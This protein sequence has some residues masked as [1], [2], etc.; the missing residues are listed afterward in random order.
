MQRTVVG[1]LIGARWRGYL[2]QLLH[3][4]LSLRPSLHLQLGGVRLL[5]LNEGVVS[6]DERAIRADYSIRR[7]PEMGIR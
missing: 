4:G 6:S 1:G 2:P 5:S 3:R 7:F